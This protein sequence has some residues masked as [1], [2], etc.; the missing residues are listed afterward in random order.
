MTVEPM[1]LQEAVHFAKRN[2][3]IDPAECDALRH[4]HR[5]LRAIADY[6]PLRDPQSLHEAAVVLR[7]VERALIEQ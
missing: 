7:A 3:V 5:T 4:A 1:T 6:A 2:L